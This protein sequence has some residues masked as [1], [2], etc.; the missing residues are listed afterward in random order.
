MHEGRPGIQPDR[1]FDDEQHATQGFRPPRRRRRP[2]RPR[3]RALRLRRRGSS[4]TPR[5]RCSSSTCRTASSPAARCRSRTATQVVPVINKLAGAFENVIVTQDWHTPGH[6]S[7]ASHACRQEAVRDD[8]ARLRHPG[9]LA[10]PL[11]AGHG[12]AALHKDLKLPTRAADHPQGLPPG[13]STATR[14]S[15]RPT[16]RP[17]PASPAT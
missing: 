1:R 10:R 15:W 12:D 16:A 13:A 3:R 14:R 9:A 11:R 5:A 2:A 17:R 4:P 8:Q 7:F 6:V